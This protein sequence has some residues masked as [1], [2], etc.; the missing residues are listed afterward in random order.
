MRY[1]Y[2]WVKTGGVLSQFLFYSLSLTQVA[3]ITYIAGP[4]TSRPPKLLLG[5]RSLNTHHVARLHLTEE[6]KLQLVVGYL[7]VPFDKQAQFTD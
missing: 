2:E 7:R 6:A 1:L 3:A 5:V 4:R